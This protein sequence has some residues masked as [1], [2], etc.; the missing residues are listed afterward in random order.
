MK[1][2]MTV[3]ELRRLFFENDCKA[4]CGG[5]ELTNEKVRRELFELEDQDAIVNCIRMPGW[6]KDCIIIT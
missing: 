5:K 6:K 4:I 3:R 2:Q 1:N